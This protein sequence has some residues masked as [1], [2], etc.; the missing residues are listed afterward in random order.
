MPAPLKILFVTPGLPSPPSFGG[1]ARMQGLMKTLARTHA[2][3]ALSYVNPAEDH[4]RSIAATSDYCREVVTVPNP[5]L[6][7]RG[8]GKR[9]LQLR[10]LLSRH[11]FEALCYDRPELVRALRTLLARQTWDVVNVEFSFMAACRDALSADERRRAGA[12][13]LDEHNVEYEILRRTAAS[14]TTPARRVYN[15]VNWRKLKREEV[16]AWKLYDGCAVTSRVDEQQLLRDVPSA[17][18]AVVPNAAD[19]DH[20]KPRPEAAPPEPYTLL[21]FGAF[22]YFPNTDGLHFFVNEVLPLVAA[23]CPQVKLRVVG[24]TPPELKA[25]SGKHIEMLGF[26]DDLRVQIERAAV[27][28]APLRVGGGTRL[29]IVEAMAMGKAVVSTH[30][31]AE[32]LD[33]THGRDVLLADEPAAFA[34]QVVRALQSPELQE[35][36]GRAARKQVEEHYGWAESVRRLEALYDRLL[37]ATGS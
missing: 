17:A 12:F 27:V 19:I 24:H 22:N 35:Q 32:G 20:F 13:V 14:E 30:L 2:V 16:G 23:Q 37:S 11:S 10:S 9:L 15:G 26:V 31:G 5:A 21:F 18:T 4:A 7:L 36:L 25:L 6:A 34:E 1:Q 3:S 33:V 29:K 28:I 8:R